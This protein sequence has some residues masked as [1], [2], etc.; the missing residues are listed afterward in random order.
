MRQLPSK[1]LSS[2][3]RSRLDSRSSTSSACV[4]GYTRAARQAPRPWLGGWF[5]NAHRPA[6]P[7]SAIRTPVLPLTSF[8]LPSRFALTQLDRVCSTTP[9]LRAASATLWPD[10][11][12]R[13][14]SCLNSSLYLPRFPFLIGPSLSLFTA[15]QLRDT[16][17][18]G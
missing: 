9:R 8:S 12:R 18:A 10:S 2:R 6:A 13:T 17:R 1:R 11:T 7:L 4:S 16:V 15:A 14:P 5:R 3:V